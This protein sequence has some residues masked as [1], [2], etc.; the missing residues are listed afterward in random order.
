MIASRASESQTRYWILIQKKKKNTIIQRPLQNN[1]NE[2]P[3]LLNKS[4]SPDFI[5]SL[6][7][8]SVIVDLTSDGFKTSLSN[9]S[10]SWK[11]DVTPVGLII[12]VSGSF[13]A[14]GCSTTSFCE[15]V[16][17][18]SSWDWL[19]NGRVLIPL[20]LKEKKRVFNTKDTQYSKED[21]FFIYRTIVKIKSSVYE[22]YYSYLYW[23]LFS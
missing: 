20:M 22:N 15:L 10:R 19:S 8:S 21:F 7:C 1:S 4:C 23:Y 9:F 3:L 12:S 13:L 14:L 6:L 5:G 11:I 17:I 16:S 18:L 2:L